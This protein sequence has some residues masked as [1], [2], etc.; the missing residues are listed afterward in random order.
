MD[1]EHPTQRVT[2]LWVTR[3]V[4]W[5]TLTKHENSLCIIN[6]TLA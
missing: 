2:L 3:W 1:F 6:G 5:R 4:W